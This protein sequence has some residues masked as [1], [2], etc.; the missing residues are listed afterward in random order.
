MEE[1]PHLSAKEATRKAMG[2]ITGPIVAITLVLLSV[3]VPVAFIPGIS[4]Q[5]FQQ[6]PVA[7]AISMV[8]SAI[9]ALSRTHRAAVRDA[10]SWSAAR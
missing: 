9:N 4:G 7:V 10:Y 6:F 8:I 2:E 3:F 5:L 1:E